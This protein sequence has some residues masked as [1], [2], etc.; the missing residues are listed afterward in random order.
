MPLRNL[1]NKP[2]FQ[3]YLDN[4]LELT[5]EEDELFCGGWAS[6]VCTK[7]LICDVLSTV[8]CCQVYSRYTTTR[9]SKSCSN[10][11]RVYLP[12]YYYTWW[13]VDYGFPMPDLKIPSG[14][15]QE[16][17]W[18]AAGWYASRYADAKLGFSS[19][20]TERLSWFSLL[21]SFFFLFLSLF[22]SSL[23]LS[24]FP[25]RH[26]LSCSRGWPWNCSPPA[27]VPGG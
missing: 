10:T 1:I 13:S 23:P 21:P 5:K 19:Q 4:P 6:W 25:L 26:C 2:R 16:R 7:C 20:M 9:W 27:L 22:S 12:E 3:F 14:E 17:I 24:I 18:K 11:I 8:A 15:V